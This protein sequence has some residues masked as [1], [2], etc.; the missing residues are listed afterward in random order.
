MIKDLE[1][2]GSRYLI[3]IGSKGSVT[4]KSRA[5]KGKPLKVYG[6]V[7]DGCRYVNLIEY[8]EVGSLSYDLEAIKDFCLNGG[9]LIPM[10]EEQVKEASRQ[11]ELPP[12]L[13]D[14]TLIESLEQT[15]DRFNKKVFIEY[16]EDH[17]R[18]YTKQYLNLASN[19][20]SKFRYNVQIKSVYDNY[21]RS[22]R[23][24]SFICDNESVAFYNVT[25]INDKEL[26]EIL[27]IIEKELKVRKPNEQQ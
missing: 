14:N 1:L 8:K 12:L 17:T 10:T 9:E 2:F 20:F 5:L 22:D 27:S 11:T 3:D 13:N 4:V 18:Y 16:L 23:T 7:K 19:G 26:K 21:S 25:Q 6:K 24:Q 15:L